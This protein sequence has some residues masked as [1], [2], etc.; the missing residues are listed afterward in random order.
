M[1]ISN[2]SI[3]NVLGVPSAEL[4]MDGKRLAVIA[5]GN[6]RGKSSIAEAV[7]LCLAGASERAPNKKDWGLLVTEGA[8]G[9]KV[10]IQFD[11]GLSARLSLPSGSGS[12][13][14]AQLEEHH[15]AAWSVALGNTLLTLQTPKMRRA[16]ISKLLGDVSAHDEIAKKLVALGH[17]EHLVEAITPLLRTGL[18][19]AQTEAQAKARDAKAEWRAITTENW[20]AAKAPE[21]TPAGD[22]PAKP[23][24]SA[25]EYLRLAGAA[26]TKIEELQRQIGA[27]SAV[28]P[29]AEVKDL[30]KLAKLFAER[31]SH[32]KLLADSVRRFD[33]RIAELEQMQRGARDD[34]SRLTCPCCKEQLQLV[35]QVLEKFVE[36]SEAEITELANSLALAKADREDEKKALE[37]ATAAVGESETAARKL[38]AYDNAKPVNVDDLNRQIEEQRAEHD[39]LIG[40]VENLRAYEAWISARDRALNVH[41]VVVAWQD[42]AT[43]LGDPSLATTEADG[44]T[45]KLNADLS[46]VC[47]GLGWSP[48]TMAEDGSLYFGGRPTTFCSISERWR[49]DAALAVSIARLLSIGIVLLD[50]VDVLEIPVRPRLFRWLS[51]ASGLETVLTFATLK[52]PPQMP[53]SVATLWLGS[54]EVPVTAAVTVE[55]A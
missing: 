3:E 32:R 2:I 15:R 7:R 17:P 25:S 49:T 36:V 47:E 6:A 20:G 16:L 29:D 10:G 46:I 55:A 40:E 50:Q 11:G 12:S 13:P 41:K 33:E 43:A 35:D 30:R 54:T 45:D 9:G 37:S 51:T 14:L 22:C 48:V 28:I 26:S 42:L 8:M 24:K 18:E 1:K 27:A 52:S 38:K 23:K 31:E 53:S 34:F 5:G 39:R 44:P 4:H 21:W 19:S